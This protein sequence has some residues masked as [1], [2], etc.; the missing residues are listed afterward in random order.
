LVRVKVRSLS[1]LTEYLDDELAWRKR[2]LTTAKFAIARGRP[3][4]QTMAIR[5]GICLLYAHWEGFVKKAAE[6]YLELVSRRG[7]RLAEVQPNIVAAALHGQITIAGKSNRATLRT[8][9]AR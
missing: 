8:T 1:E 7:L 3:H 4:E 9:L 2:E 6:A 5:G